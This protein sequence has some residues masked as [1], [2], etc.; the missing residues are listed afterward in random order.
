MYFLGDFMRF[1]L[2]SSYCHKN[3]KEYNNNTH[4]KILSLLLEKMKMVYPEDE[5]FSKKEVTKYLAKIQN[6]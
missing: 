1:I 5:K 6:D 3:N 4:E 2:D